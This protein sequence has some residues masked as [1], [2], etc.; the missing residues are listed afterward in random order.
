MQGTAS[1]SDRTTRSGR[2]GEC[3][4]GLDALDLGEPAKAA[5]LAGMRNAYSSS[6]ESGTSA[7]MADRSPTSE[8]ITMPWTI[9]RKH[10]HVAVVTMNT[11]K[12]NAQNPAFFDDLHA[13][14]DRL[15]A[16]F[17][18]CA[19]VLTGTG[20]VFSAG[21]DL[22]HH[23]AMYRAPQSQGDRRLVRGL[24]RHQSSPV[25]L[26]PAHRRGDQ[27]PCL[28]GR[29]HHGDRLRL[30]DRCGRRAAVCAE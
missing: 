7:L 29:V 20:K 12:A 24:S 4:A 28:C 1:C 10:D 18:E 2:P 26:S 6:T 8:G 22:D 3:I 14:F 23:F 13:A 11:N 25:H 19:V 21:L 30:P 15:E 16:E 9:E 5:F 17:N 27:W